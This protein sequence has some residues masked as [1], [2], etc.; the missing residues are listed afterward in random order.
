MPVSLFAR[1]RK[2][3]PEFPAPLAWVAATVIGCG[4]GYGGNGV[5]G[6]FAPVGLFPLALGAIVGLA[7]GGVWLA[8][9]EATKLSVLGSAVFAAVICVATMHYAAYFT[10]IR[11]E[12]ERIAKI[13]PE[14]I[15]F[16]PNVKR[17]ATWLGNFGDYMTHEMAQGRGLGSYHVQGA[18][19]IVWWILDGLAIAGAATFA[20]LTPTGSLIAAA[21]QA[22]RHENQAGDAPDGP[23]SGAV[24]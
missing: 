2:Q 13:P 5:Q 21:A 12:E 18:G 6:V 19:L 9:R 17:E 24:S 16:D 23:D 22:S 20:A 7:V 3:D 10:A 15:L 14:A 1:V 11:A 4:A 8:R